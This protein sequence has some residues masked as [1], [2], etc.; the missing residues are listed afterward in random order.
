MTK[1]ESESSVFKTFKN[2]A[3]VEYQH[4][5]GLALAISEVI[6]RFGKA[7]VGY[8]IVQDPVKRSDNSVES[9]E[10]MLFFDPKEK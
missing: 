9:G 1:T 7:P 10:L 5:Y 4:S 2:T 3:T 8:I 6:D